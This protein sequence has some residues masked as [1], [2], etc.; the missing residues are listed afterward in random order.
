MDTGDTRPEAAAPRTS[1][2][3]LTRRRPV[4]RLLG[5]A[6]GSPLKRTMGVAQLK[7]LGSLGAG[8]WIAS[9]AWTAAGLVVHGLHGIRHSQ[10]NQPRDL[11]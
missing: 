2:H 3:S 10:L 9:G 11:V 8:T 7:L 4:Q 6:A 5:D 1:T